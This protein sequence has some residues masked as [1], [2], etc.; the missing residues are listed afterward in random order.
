MRL[1][2]IVLFLL[3]GSSILLATAAVVLSAVCLGVLS[4]F[5]RMRRRPPNF[6]AAFVR[7]LL[8]GLSSTA[9]Q[10][11]GDARR[12]YRT[13]FGTGALRGSH[14]EELGEFLQ[15]V[16]RRILSAPP[17]SP[18]DRL[19]GK[20]RLLRE[21]LAANDRA[22]E[23]ERMCVPFSG[24]P[25]YEREILVELL[26]LPVED[27]TKVSA[28]LGAL[29]KAIRFRQDRLERLD[30]ESYRSL[31]LAEWGWYGT[32]ALAILVVILGLLCLGV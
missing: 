22:L 25:E 6:R 14:L 2:G 4:R 23:V 27:K 8:R 29:A 13:F 12:A 7:K 9:I 30:D 32:L 1:Q 3:V 28:K 18:D 19:Q 11:I 24:T 15:E 10:D 5:E 17:G 16:M 31:R 21:L 26:E 20:I